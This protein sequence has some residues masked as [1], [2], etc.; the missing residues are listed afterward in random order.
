MCKKKTTEQFIEDARLVHGDKYDYSLVEYIHSREPI[1]IICPTHGVF[2][3]KPYHHL[4]NK[5]CKECSKLF[6]V[7][8]KED[9]VKL[10]EKATLYLIKVYKDDE[11][12]YKIGKTKDSV[13]KR[14]SN[15]NIKPYNY[16]I[17]QT[18]YDDSGKIFDLEIELHKKFYSYK[19]KPLYKFAGYGECYTLELPIEEVIDTWKNK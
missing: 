15:T 13:K 9:Y 1:K 14:F 19:Y 17:V 6:N 5:G 2:E 3:Q 11:E 4:L 8:K 7:Y 10:S 16:E 18:Y 12:F